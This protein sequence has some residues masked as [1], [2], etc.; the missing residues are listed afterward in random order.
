MKLRIM[1]VAASLLMAG[2][3]TPA[4]ENAEGSDAASES[5]SSWMKPDC[6]EKEEHG[7]GESM[8]EHHGHGAY[9][10][11]ECEGNPSVVVTATPDAVS[12][13]NIHLEIDQFYLAPLN[14]S[15]AHQAGEGHAHVYLDGVKLGR[16]YTEWI[17]IS[18]EPGN[19][20]VQITLNSNDH[21]DLSINGVQVEHTVAVTVP[22]AMGSHGGH[23][24][25]AH[26]DGEGMGVSVAARADPKDASNQIIEI[27]VAGFQFD[28]AGA[29][30]EH[31][32]GKGHAHIYLNGAKLGRVYGNFYALGGL[33]PGDHEVKITLNGNDHADYQIDGETVNHAISIHVPETE[34]D[35]GHEGHGGHSGY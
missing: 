22:E 2:C 13:I 32:Q 16:V 33:E 21:S 20:T 11:P 31:E 15:T 9:E 14:V 18:A 34:A 28:P 27:A 35:N 25:H 5:E 12:G 7:H 23:D 17:H 26:H 8:S 24:G 29:S 3:A 6:P 1:L 10:L 19:H 30:E 4:G